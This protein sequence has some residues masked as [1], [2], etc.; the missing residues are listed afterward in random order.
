ML[1]NILLSLH[2][3]G[4][5]V[6]GIVALYCAYVLLT[7]K[8]NAYRRLAITL[9]FLAGFELLTGALLSIVSIQLSAAAV[10]QR[11]VLYLALFIILEAILF[12]RMRKTSYP[13][14]VRAAVSPV[15]AGFTLLL[16]SLALGF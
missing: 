2:V 5:C 6:S 9:G 15:A 12:I 10:C 3:A 13:F 16:G 14:P 7:N 8:E 1:Y 11:I 4:G